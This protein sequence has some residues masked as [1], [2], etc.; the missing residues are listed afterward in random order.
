MVSVSDTCHSGYNMCLNVYAAHFSN[1]KFFSYLPV[2][3]VCSKFFE[4]THQFI[5]CQHH[6][7]KKGNHRDMNNNLFLPD[8]TSDKESIVNS[9]NAWEEEWDEDEHEDTLMLVLFFQMIS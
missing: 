2:L 7:L 6:I 3:Y 9:D 8:C 4:S 5:G 1:L